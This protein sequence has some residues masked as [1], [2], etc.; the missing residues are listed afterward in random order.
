MFFR[1]QKYDTVVMY[2]LNVL[3]G[4]R[5]IMYCKEIPLKFKKKSYER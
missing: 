5:P 3:E 4:G 2:Y 1:Q